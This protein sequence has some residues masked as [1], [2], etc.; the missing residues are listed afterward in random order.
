MSDLQLKSASRKSRTVPTR[1]NETN[2]GATAVISAVALLFAC[3][4]PAAGAAPGSSASSSGKTSV[5][6]NTGTNTGAGLFTHLKLPPNTPNPQNIQQFRLN[7]NGLQVVLCER[8]AAPIVSTMI[9]YHVGSRNEAVGY[10]GATHFLE[11]MMFKGAKKFDP[12]HRNGIDDVLR[13]LGGYNNATTSFDR[14]NYF[15]IVPSKDLNL[16]LEIEAD[17]MRNLALRQADRDAE[18]TVVRNELEGSQD[19]ATDILQDNIFATAFREHP[20]HHPTL[21]WRSDVEGVPLARLRKFYDEFYWPNNATLILIGDFDTRAVLPMIAGNFGKIH[22]SP[23]PFPKIYTQEPP[24][25]GERRFVVQ[26]GSEQPK[27]MVAFHVPNATSKEAYTLDTIE[28]LLGNEGNKS[29]IL[30]KKLIDTGLASDVWAYGYSLKDPGLFVVY[31]APAPKVPLEKLEAK[32]IEIVEGLGKEPVT[33]EQLDRAKQSI[34]KH[35]RLSCS[36]PAGL[37]DLLAEAIAAADVNW[38]LN[39]PANLRKVTAADVERVAQ[40]YFTA[41]NRSVG[42][43]RPKEAPRTEETVADQSENAATSE[44]S[45]TSETNPPPAP[46]PASSVEHKS[47]SPLKIS[48]ALGSG[49]FSSKTRRVI[50]G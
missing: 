6:R 17:R 49:K 1:V 34:L 4:F 25:E 7:S 21:G 30:Y 42:Y 24:Q 9:V 5:R 47:E 26:R 11:H 43:Y 38:L 45:E 32:I 19:R 22:R 10:T 37:A 23:A 39:Y 8:H 3:F 46:A 27:L 16:C 29:S 2:S 20:Y 35:S 28:Y 15:E 41:T 31:A 48:K 12:E 18:M 13:P 40:K 33:A 36:D 44:T 50:F 14:T